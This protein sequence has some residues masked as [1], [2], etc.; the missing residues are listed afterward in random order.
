M[1]FTLI[2]VVAAF[3][4]TTVVLFFVTGIFSENAKQRSAAA[5]LLRVETTASAALDLNEFVIPPFLADLGDYKS[6]LDQVAAANF[7]DD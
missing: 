6:K 7:L 5:E 1:G 3:F 4:L 2:E